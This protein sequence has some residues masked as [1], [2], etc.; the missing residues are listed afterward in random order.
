M[1]RT[2]HARTT[3]S[4][5]LV[6]RNKGFEKMVLSRRHARERCSCSWWLFLPS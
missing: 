1:T 6:W 4:K 5:G 2:N 3:H